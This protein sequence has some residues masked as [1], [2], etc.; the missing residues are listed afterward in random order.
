MPYDTEE[1]VE[2]AAMQ[3]IGLATLPEF[4]QMQLPLEER[5]IRS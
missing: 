5:T 2:S 3:M 1:G 4:D